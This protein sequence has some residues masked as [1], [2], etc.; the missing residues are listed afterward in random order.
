MRHCLLIDYA[1]K[2]RSGILGQGSYLSTGAW[3]KETENTVLILNDGKIHSK[4]NMHGS[5]GGTGKGKQP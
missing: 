5:I 3:G 4:W 2:Q 1:C